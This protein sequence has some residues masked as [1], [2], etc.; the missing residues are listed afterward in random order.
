[1]ALRRLAAAAVLRRPQ[2]TPVLDSSGGGLLFAGP[3]F[4]KFQEAVRTLV[5]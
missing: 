5:L 2:P 4:L 1:M 3:A